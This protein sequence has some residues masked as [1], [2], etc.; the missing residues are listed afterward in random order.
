[1]KRGAPKLPAAAPSSKKADQK[2][3]RASG[4][5][6]AAELNQKSSFVVDPIHGR[7]S[8]FFDMLLSGSLDVSRVFK[9]VGRGGV[10]RMLAMGKQ[11]QEQLGFFKKHLRFLEL[12]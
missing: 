10:S 6:S 8:S 3:K 11:E 5:F 7:T 4:V 2:R 9:S 12:F 1:M